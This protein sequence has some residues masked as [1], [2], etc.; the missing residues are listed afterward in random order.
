M[1]PAP[2]DFVDLRFLADAGVPYTIWIRIGAANNDVFSDSLWVQFSDAWVNGA[3]VYP[4]DSSEALLVNGSDASNALN[5]W[6][7]SNGAYWLSQPATIMF[8]KTGAHTIRIQMREDGVQ[9]DQIVLSPSRY[10]N[11]APG[12][13]AGDRTIVAK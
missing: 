13:P 1:L 3:H 8:A 9:F 6:G 11:R 2:A 4:L 12:L 5:G 7:W 10:L